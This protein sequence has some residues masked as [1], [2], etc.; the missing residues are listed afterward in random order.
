MLTAALKTNASDSP[1][2]CRAIEGKEDHPNEIYRVR[3]KVFAASE[4][5]VLKP[6]QCKKGVVMSFDPNRKDGL[7]PSFQTAVIRKMSGLT[8][9]DIRVTIDGAVLTH[10]SGKRYIKVVNVIA[11]E[12]R[13][14][15]GDRNSRPKEGL[16]DDS[17]EGSRSTTVADE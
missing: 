16:Q 8:K 7:W 10:S 15:T 4:I 9:D 14:E 11:V 12:G 2:V 5:V 17:I 1:T 3:G 6:D 13:G